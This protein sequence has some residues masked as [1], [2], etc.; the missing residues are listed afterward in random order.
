M[1]YYSLSGAHDWL[2]D[3]VDS[4]VSVLSVP[5]R[6]KFT[7]DEVLRATYDERTRAAV[8]DEQTQAE[9]SDNAGP[10]VS[11]R[12]CRFRIRLVFESGWRLSVRDSSVRWSVFWG[13][14]VTRQQSVGTLRRPNRS[15]ET[16]RS[17]TRRERN[18]NR[19]TVGSQ[20]AGPRLTVFESH[21]VNRRG[22]ATHTEVW[23][24]EGVSHRA[25][26]LTALYLDYFR[27][28]F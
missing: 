12:G 23:E 18:A 13:A 4:E 3:D 8:Y 1:P 2:T 10:G 15:L 28:E 21:G 17:Y 9:L 7:R 27:L 24:M 25:A 20:Q 14:R 26:S 19:D 5:L 11:T 6:C 22:A 16:N